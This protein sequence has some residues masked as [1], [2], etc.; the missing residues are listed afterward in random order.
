[1][2]LQNPFQL[3]TNDLNEIKNLISNLYLVQTKPDPEEEL[4]DLKGAAKFLKIAPGTIYNQIKNIPHS[5]KGKRL[6]FSKKELISWIKEGKRHTISEIKEQVNQSLINQKNVKPKKTT[7][8]LPERVK[9]FT[10]TAELATQ[11]IEEAAEEAGQIH[12]DI[13]KN[14][15]KKNS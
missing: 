4:T 5:K 9:I 2:D 13:N 3:I 10:E 15:L 14:Q 8:T 11:T 7:Y 12:Y 1:M 6:Y